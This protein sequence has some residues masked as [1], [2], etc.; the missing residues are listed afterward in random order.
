MYFVPA[1]IAIWTPKRLNTVHHHSGNAGHVAVGPKEAEPVEECAEEER[2][3]ALHLLFKIST[4]AF[5]VLN[6]A[7]GCGFLPIVNVLQLGLMLL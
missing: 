7:V 6:F 4:V 1:V 3:P 2:D 5:I